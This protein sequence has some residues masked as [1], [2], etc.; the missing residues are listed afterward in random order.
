MKTIEKGIT[1][2]ERLAGKLE[3]RRILEMRAH[4]PP[5]LAI[6]VNFDIRKIP[7]WEKIRV[8]MVPLSPLK[9][10]EKEWA[11][12]KKKADC[13]LCDSVIPVMVFCL[14]KG[15]E[16][17]R[18]IVGVW[19]ILD[20]IDLKKSRDRLME[21]YD[22]SGYTSEPIRMAYALTNGVWPKGHPEK[23]SDPVI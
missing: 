14:E 15:E 6:D 19:G 8:V 1:F 20:P 7:N 3:H 22:D 4:V 21:D 17:N 16:P 10:A 13:S 5:W 12:A 9:G 23:F 11:A 2:Q 18:N